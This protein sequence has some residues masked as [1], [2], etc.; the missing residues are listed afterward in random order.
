MTSTISSKG[1]VTLPAALRTRL[2][3]GTGTKLEF[4]TNGDAI[5]AREAFDVGEMRSVLGCAAQFEQ[6]KSSRKILTDMRGYD[7]ESL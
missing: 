7:R 3:W 5:I 2:G 6:G 1:Q 4:E